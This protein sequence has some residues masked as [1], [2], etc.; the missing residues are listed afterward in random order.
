VEA[1]SGVKSLVSTSQLH[2]GTRGLEGGPGAYY[3]SH[4]GG[5]CSLKDLRDFSERKMVQMGMRIR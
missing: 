5:C 4:I 1:H 2:T 3:E